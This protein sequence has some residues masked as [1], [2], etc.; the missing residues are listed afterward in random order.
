MR[1][2]SLTFA[3]GKRQPALFSLA[4]LS[5]IKA[6]LPSH[7]V[8]LY[9]F[10]IT[11]DNKFMS[12]NKDVESL[13]EAMESKPS[14]IAASVPAA[15]GALP[16]VIEHQPNKR[17]LT[18]RLTLALIVIGGGGAGL[19]WWAHHTPPLPNW[20]VFGN[21]R[22]EA[23]P[24]DIATKFPGRILELRADEGDMVSA[25]QVVALMD[26]R[27]L[28]QSLKK[29]EAQ[30]EQ[31]QKAIGEAQANLE[32]THSQAVLADQEMTRADG[33]IKGGWITKETYDQRRQQLDAAKAAETAAQARL[34]EAEHA[35]NA[36]QH[37]AGLIRVN[38]NDN[39]LVAPHDGR[40]EYRIANVGE[41]LPA[42]GK[43]F[44]MLD[45]SYVYMDVYLPTLKA[46]KVKIGSDARI[47]LDA[48][49]DR[50]IPAK[51][52][53]I[54]IRRNSHRRWWRRKPIETS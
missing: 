47:V 8:T 4:T 23:D 16:E 49:P 37:D 6:R 14:A 44:T 28:E 25:G 1:E 20:I 3:H 32:Q 27:D 53:F 31:A 12:E 18:R 30:I 54:A 26:T 43:V 52:S 13:S 10:V 15:R 38:I 46:D 5:Q 33:L 45:T 40:I 21:G 7:A 11:A 19:Y 51:V 9:G 22:L 42:G 17:W 39:T 2:K 34:N 50:P 41:V 36:A 29:S 24:I 35:L 48:Y